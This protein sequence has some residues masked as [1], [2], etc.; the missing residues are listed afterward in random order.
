[1]RDVTRHLFPTRLEIT[2]E[3]VRQR[4]SVLRA[5][6]FNEYASLFGAP[7]HDP[8]MPEWQ[9]NFN[10][11]LAFHQDNPSVDTS[12]PT[13]PQLE[14]WAE[15]LKVKARLDIPS[16]WDRSR[17]LLEMA[18][19][20]G[21]SENVTAEQLL[22]DPEIL[23]KI[24][25]GCAKLMQVVPGSN[26]APA[27]GSGAPVPVAQTHAGT[28]VSSHQSPP[29]PPN[30]VP[31]SDPTNPA[32]AAPSP[33]D[34]SPRRVS[35]RSSG[36]FKIAAEPSTHRPPSNDYLLA[37]KDQIERMYGGVGLWGHV[38]KGL[39]AGPKPAASTSPA[40]PASQPPRTPSATP[41]P[42]ANTASSAPTAPTTPASPAAPAASGTPSAARAA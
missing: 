16:S 20:G 13:L 39:M 40:A 15:S 21:A 12:H 4:L 38:F 7:P 6:T 22:E 14:Q 28:P 23:S 33:Q 17:I 9:E 8:D 1:M 27:T 37:K 24:Y 29:S 10:H 11:F 18:K 2:D 41:A 5:S 30:N 26:P 32:P 19:A 35:E 31:P 34:P 3:G 25:R 42:A 36:G